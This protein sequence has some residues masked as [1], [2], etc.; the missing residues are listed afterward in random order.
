MR[1]IFFVALYF[2]SANAFS[3]TVKILFDATKAESA[4]NADWVIDADLHNLG[5][6]PGAQ[7]NNGNESN[8]Q[9]FPT[10]AQSAITAST[11]EMYWEGA[12]SNWGIDCVKQGYEAE[13]LPYNGS[14][15]YNNT[16]NPQDL[17]N[18]KIFIVCEPNILFTTAEKNALLNYVYNGG[19]LFMIS[20]HNQSD[21]NGDGHDS[22]NIWNDLMSANP[23]GI[24]FNLNNYS[25]T[26][27]SVIASLTDSV[28][29]GLYG[30]V[31]EVLWSNG[32]DMTLDTTINPTAKGV[33]FKSGLL[34]DN[35]AVMFAYARYGKGKVAAMGD[36]SPADDGSGDSNDALYNGYIADANGNHRKLIMNATVWLAAT[37]STVGINDTQSELNKVDIFCAQKNLFVKNNS[38]QEVTLKVFDT[39]GKIIFENSISKNEEEKRFSLSNFKSGIYIVKA[40]GNKNIFTKKIII[41]D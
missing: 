41:T 31:T 27:N 36:S 21:R 8:A 25:Q 39:L 3:Q 11:P 2:A 20:D 10:A 16:A 17:A 28:A 40:I 34:N 5:W 26:S 30:H 35:A 29:S 9:R 18:Y 32:T 33:V 6:N 7:I 24:T 38:E 14:I 12:L 15:T 13:T 19:S 22:P 1:K 4:N 37:N 23:F